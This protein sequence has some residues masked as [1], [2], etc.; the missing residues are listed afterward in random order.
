MSLPELPAID[1]NIRSIASL[2]EAIAD[3]QTTVGIMKTDL[4]TLHASLLLVIQTI[5]GQKKPEI[6]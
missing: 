4:L 1:T 3:L 5:N 6:K 2:E